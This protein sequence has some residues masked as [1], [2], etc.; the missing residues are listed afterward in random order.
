M[1][2]F[3]RSKFS[4]FAGAGAMIAA[5]LLM[6]ASPATASVTGARIC[7]AALFN[8]LSNDWYVRDA[9]HYGMLNRGQSKVIP[10]VLSAG[11]TYRIVAGGCEDAFDVDIAVYDENGGLVSSDRD[12][13]PLAVA[14][15]TPRWTGRFYIKVTM[16]QVRPRSGGA[17]HYVVQYAYR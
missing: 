6:T 14:A 3:F 7:A 11:R 15:V 16:A 5:S 4:Q 2:S 17:A 9:F 10:T 8:A 12:R 1:N 13:S